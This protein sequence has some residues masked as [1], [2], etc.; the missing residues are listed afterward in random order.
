[1]GLDGVIFGDLTPHEGHTH[2][3]WVCPDCGSRAYTDGEHGPHRI[4]C[5]TT[6]RQFLVV[7]IPSIGPRDKR[8]SIW[9]R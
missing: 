6:G 9:R 1:M 7:G 8:A 5:D 3:E 4:T 2:L